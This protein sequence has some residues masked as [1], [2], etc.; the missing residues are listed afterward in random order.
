MTMT[1]D[2]AREAL[3][4]KGA[5]KL[6]EEAEETQQLASIIYRHAERLSRCGSAGGVQPTANDLLRGAVSMLASVHAPTA[7]ICVE[8]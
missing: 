5:L 1:Q 2:E 8:A 4:M 7:V 6:L 3:A